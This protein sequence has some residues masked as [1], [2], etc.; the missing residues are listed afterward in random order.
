MLAIVHA[1]VGGL[2]GG[3]FHSLI[4]IIIASVGLHFLFDMI[5]HWDGHFDRQEFK[6]SGKI[7]VDS[8]FF[9]MVA[10]EY[11]ATIFLIYSL[12]R[13]FDRNKLVI[14]GCIAG[15]LPDLVSLGYK[16]KLKKSKSYMRLL[17]FHSKIQRETSFKK[18]LIIH[19][20]IMV[21]LIIVAV[22]IG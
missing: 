3:E 11:I 1:L 4:L 6:K 2:I 8:S 10:L 22:I 21:A 15:I 20:I 16:T 13:G 17:N 14:L 7:K 9:I 18:S 5:P 19:G 12:Y